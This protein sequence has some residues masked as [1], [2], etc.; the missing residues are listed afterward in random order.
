METVASW[1]VRCKREQPSGIAR[2]G[3]STSN[4]I[5]TYKLVVHV[6]KYYVHHQKYTNPKSLICIEQQNLED[7]K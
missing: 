7:N 1:S 3:S 6:S 5:F 2:K 4:R